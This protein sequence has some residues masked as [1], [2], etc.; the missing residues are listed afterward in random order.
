MIKKGDKII[1]G[2]VLAV[3][4]VSLVI[5]RMMASGGTQV[6]IT[7]NGEVYG[8]YDLKENR[9]IYIEGG[10]GTNTVKIQDGSV[11]MIEASCPDQVCVHTHPLSKEK[12][13]II[14]CLPHKVV[15]ELKE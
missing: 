4:L 15:V 11:S 9:T 5:M 2:V 6:V 7:Q 13:G 8:T 14:V 10:S 3:A 1:I 12:G